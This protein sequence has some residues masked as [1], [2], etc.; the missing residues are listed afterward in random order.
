VTEPVNTVAKMYAAILVYEFA[1]TAAKYEPLYEETITL[2]LAVS[3][4]Q[5]A[6]KAR[7]FA[8]SRQSTYE[9]EY[10]ETINFLLKH[11]VDVS[12]INDNLGDG[13]EVYTRHFRDYEAYRAFETMLSGKGL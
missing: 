10:G 4:K 2:I 12:E 13:A 8:I 6:E 1:S 5:A 11:L 9:N 7:E 3:K